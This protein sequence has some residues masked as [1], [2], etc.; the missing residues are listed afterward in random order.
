MGN[1]HVQS[2][3]LLKFPPNVEKVGRFG[4]YWFLNV[5]IR[6][7]YKLVK[8]RFILVCGIARTT[9]HELGQTSPRL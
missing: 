5:V 6:D 7:E 4:K 3:T 9:G 1:T 2:Q 8:W